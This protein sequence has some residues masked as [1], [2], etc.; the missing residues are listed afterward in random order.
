MK[1]DNVVDITTSMAAT[2]E[3]TLREQPE[4]A[5]LIDH[6]EAPANTTPRIPRMNRGPRQSDRGAGDRR[7]GPPRHPQVGVQACGD[8]QSLTPR[9]D[10]AIHTPPPPPGG[11]VISLHAY[12]RH[13]AAVAAVLVTAAAM[14]AAWWFA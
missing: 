12:R 14:A 11:T 9:R 2:D 8:K 4:F 1:R 10:G 6:L 5:R 3:R 13:S 7:N